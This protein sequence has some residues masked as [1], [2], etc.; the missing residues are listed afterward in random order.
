MYVYIHIHTHVYTNKSD[1]PK[2]CRVKPR[3]KPTEKKCKKNA[4]LQIRPFCKLKRITCHRSVS[5]IT[6]IA[7]FD[8]L[9]DDW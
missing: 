8:E 2:T 6:R 3:K 5:W 9:F 1:P 4:R 7:L